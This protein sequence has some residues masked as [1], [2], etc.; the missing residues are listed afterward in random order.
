MKSRKSL[1]SHN[2]FT[3]GWV[4]PVKH[5]QIAEEV[6]VMTAK[7][8]HSQSLNDRPLRPWIAVKKSGEIII[9]HCNCK[10]G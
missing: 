9:T 7:V 10:A 4:G 2:Q 6:S 5:L 1:E 3:S 8:K